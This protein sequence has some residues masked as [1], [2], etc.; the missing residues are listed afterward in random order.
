MQEKRQRFDAIEQELSHSQRP[1]LP[2]PVQSRLTTVGMRIRKAIQG[3]YQATKKP[4][5]PL[6]QHE[7]MLQKTLSQPQKAPVELPETEIAAAP[8]ALPR[9][10]LVAG[11]KR[12][13]Q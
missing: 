13:R 11:S 7:M 8:Q 4:G 6:Q 1:V 10:D 9:T 3:G 12:Q 2:T 5:Q